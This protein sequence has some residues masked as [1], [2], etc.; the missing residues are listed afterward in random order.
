MQRFAEALS[1]RLFNF[2]D[3][4]RQTVLSGT[5]ALDIRKETG[6]P[7]SRKWQPYGMGTAQYPWL[8]RLVG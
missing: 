5:V 6:F 4:Y 1:R 3:K 8:Q 2:Q 7:L